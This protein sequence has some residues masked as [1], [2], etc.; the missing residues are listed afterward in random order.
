MK[1][2]KFTGQWGGRGRGHGLS[3]GLEEWRAMWVIGDG[4]WLIVVRLRV[5]WA[6]PP[7]TQKTEYPVP[8]PLVT[9]G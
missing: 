1:N 6:F 9:L 7:E 2:V 4:M 3:K 8:P 5:A